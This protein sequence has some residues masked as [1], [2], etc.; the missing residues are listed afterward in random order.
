MNAIIHTKSI[1]IPGDIVLGGRFLRMKDTGGEP[2]RAWDQG[3]KMYTDGGTSSQAW[4][5]N[6]NRTLWEVKSGEGRWGRD[7]S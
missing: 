1:P 7:Y 5:S 4:V 6:S 3:G 2:L